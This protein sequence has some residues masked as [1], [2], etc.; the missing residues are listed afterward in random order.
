M[1]T[2]LL[3]PQ[4]RQGLAHN[5]FPELGRSGLEAPG[6]ARSMA[7]A[8]FSLALSYHLTPLTT[9]VLTSLPPLSLE[10]KEDPLPDLPWPLQSTVWQGR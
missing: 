1:R 9:E 7:A 4:H 8:H 5:H 3:A 10:H 6:P 2:E